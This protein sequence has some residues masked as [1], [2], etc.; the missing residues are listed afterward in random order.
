[1][2]YTN[3][4]SKT[5]SEPVKIHIY[6]HRAGQWTTVRSFAGESEYKIDVREG[7]IVNGRR[8]VPTSAQYSV[9]P[10]GNPGTS[11]R[12]EYAEA[13]SR[14]A[15]ALQTAASSEATSRF[16]AMLN[17]GSGFILF[18]AIG[19]A[20]AEVALRE[21]RVLVCMSIEFAYDRKTQSWG[22]STKMSVQENA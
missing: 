7:P 21:A 3:L 19:Y 16:G 20:G 5:K 12:L 9:R 4:T 1:M 6:A 10:L 2:N 15:S 14:M 13:K 17:Q 11:A 18:N 8:P 22:T